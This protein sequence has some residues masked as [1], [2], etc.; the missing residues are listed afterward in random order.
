MTSQDNSRAAQP[1]RLMP[2]DLFAYY[3]TIAFREGPAERG[4]RAATAG[5]PEGHYQLAPEEGQLLRFLAELL[6]ARRFLEIGT[7]TGYSALAVA[8]TMG[9]GGHV[10]TLD[11]EPR[12]VDIGRPFWADAGVADRIKVHLGPALE[13]LERLKA[14]PPYDLALVDADKEAYGAYYERCLELV[15]PGGVIAIDNT[16]WRGRVANPADRRE[17]TVAMRELNAAIQADARVTPVVIPMGDG[18]TLARVR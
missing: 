16:L 18:L 12:F 1:N 6:G 11:V 4:L 3:E 14:A 8:L 10:D 9:D 2:P 13:S 15:R 17:K 5:I 7:F